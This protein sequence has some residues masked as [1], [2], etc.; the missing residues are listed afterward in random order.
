MAIFILT[1]DEIELLFRLKH[2]LSNDS[3]DCKR[4]YGNH[5]YSQADEDIG[6]LDGLIKKVVPDYNRM[7]V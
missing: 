1:D 5:Y 6:I 3:V 2:R 7:E 4:M